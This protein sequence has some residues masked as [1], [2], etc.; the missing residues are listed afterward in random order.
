MWLGVGLLMVSLLRGVSVGLLMVGLLMVGLM[1][2]GLLMAGLIGTLS[3]RITD[4]AWSIDWACRLHYRTVW[5][6]CKT[7]GRGVIV[8]YLSSCGR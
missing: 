7:C 3:P 4:S 2:M 6:R 8:V 5:C 1:S